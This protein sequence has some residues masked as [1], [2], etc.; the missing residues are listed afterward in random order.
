MVVD[1]KCLMLRV[2][3]R[4][5]KYISTG[6]QLLTVAPFTLLHYG[7]NLLQHTI[8][9]WQNGGCR[10]WSSSP[11]EGSIPSSKLVAD[12]GST[13]GACHFAMCQTNGG[14]YYDFKL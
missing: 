14:V 12:S 4:Q 6:S 11:G 3:L 7:G 9:T 1:C 5:G 10:S 13:P 2:N 8:N